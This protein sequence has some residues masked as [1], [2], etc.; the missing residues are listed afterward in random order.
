VKCRHC[1]APL[2]LTLL[3][4]GSSPPSNAYLTEQTLHAPEKWFPLRVLVCEQCWLAQTE[5]FSRANELFD[6]DYAYFSAFSTSWLAHCERYVAAMAKRFSLGSDSH[7]VEVAANDG[8]LLQYVKAHGIPCTGIEPTAS[9]A[10][11][12]RARGIPIVEDFFGI[13]L[14]QELAAKGKQADLM[15]AN[16]V[17]AHVPDINDFV[18][19]F[20]TLLK[21]HGV[22]TFEFPHLMRLVN[23]NQFD[24]IYHEHFSYLSLGTVGRIFAKAGL[25]IFDVEEHPTHGGSLRVFVQRADS[26][27]QPR[28]SSVDDLLSREAEAG[29]LNAAY[30]ADFQARA[31]KVKND[32][33]SFLLQAKRDG[34]R[35]AAYGAAAKGNTL[36]NYAGVRQDLISFVVDRNPAKQ[37]KYLPGS[38]IPIVAPELLAERKPDYVLILPWNIAEEVRTQQR[39]IR[40]WDGRFVAAIPRLIVFE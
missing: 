19:G 37:G 11:A 36:L 34:M 9:T 5:D 14:A 38:R 29:M 6:A 20:T 2:Q 22:A 31:D 21:P 15:V 18:A 17:L 4:L 8:Y 30:Y 25:D 40:D 28:S 23:E 16:N 3:D 12:A 27:K 33:L 10:A 1:A 7:V 35:V 13:R 39:R 32:F 24:T 26:G